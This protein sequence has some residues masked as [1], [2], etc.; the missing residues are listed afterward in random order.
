MM[1]PSFLRN[2]D[3]WLSMSIRMKPEGA[4][5]MVM[6]WCTG[7]ILKVGGLPYHSFTHSRKRSWRFCQR[8][9][10]GIC[11]GF[12]VFDTDG[13]VSPFRALSAHQCA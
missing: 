10:W 9:D 7:S 4:S 13:D 2:R 3:A 5:T 11:V 12:V 1:R 6:R 8:S